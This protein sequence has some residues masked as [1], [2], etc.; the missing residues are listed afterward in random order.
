[1]EQSQVKNLF[2]SIAKKY[3]FLN[4]LLSLGIDKYWRWSV[5][6][7][8]KKENPKIILDLATGTGDFAISICKI[9][10]EIIY[11]VDISE[12]MIK[13]GKEKVNKNNLSEIIKFE[14]GAS[15]KLRF[16]DNTFDAITV[17]FGVRNYENLILGLS[18]MHRVLK[19]NGVV[20]ILEF[21]KPKIFPFKQIYFFYFKNI[22]PFIG[23][24]V[25]K[26]NFAYQYLPDTVLKFPEGEEFV[27]I[28]KSVG[29]VRVLERRF[30]FGISTLY[31]CY[32]N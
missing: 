22:L 21:S 4:H 1:M 19:Q 3:D 13:I 20:A 9:K 8:L 15:E 16:Q 11:A 23:K 7:L 6:K 18:E 30:T 17:G 14:I 31:L 26:N 12:E 2:N 32:K 5:V 10:P 29:F 27:K 25:S 28:L 24:I